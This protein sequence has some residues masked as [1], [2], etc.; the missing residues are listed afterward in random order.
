MQHLFDHWIHLVNSNPDD[1]SSMLDYAP[2]HRGSFV[3]ED[4]KTTKKEKRE[5]F[6]E[7][8]SWY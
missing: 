6:Q 3:E 5:N 2:E 4:E 1:A 7:K 8:R